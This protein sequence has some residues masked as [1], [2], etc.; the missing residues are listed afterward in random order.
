[1]TTMG[2]I[3]TGR[4][5]RLEELIAEVRDRKSGNPIVDELENQINELLQQVALLQSKVDQYPI[6]PGISSRNGNP[7]YNKEMMPEILG[8]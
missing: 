7:Q 6:P 2:E 3:V 1:M 5:N 4:L 8:N